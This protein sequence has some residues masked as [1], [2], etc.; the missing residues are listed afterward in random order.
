MINSYIKGIAHYVPEK[1]LTNDDLSKM[2]DTSDDWIKTRT[3]IHQRHTVGDTH[4]GPAD[5]AVA[6]SEILFER[7]C[8]KLRGIK[9]LS[10]DKRIE[11]LLFKVTSASP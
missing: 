5:L 4:L 10:F 2:M 9:I 1:V 11:I 6:A 8:F 7:R 3:G